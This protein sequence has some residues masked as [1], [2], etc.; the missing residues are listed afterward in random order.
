MAGMQIRLLNAGVGNTGQLQIWAYV[1]IGLVCVAL[2][3]CFIIPC[4]L[5]RCRREEQHEEDAD[6]REAHRRRD[7]AASESRISH[8]DSLSSPWTRLLSR[9]KTDVMREWKCQSG[10]CKKS[11]KK[12]GTG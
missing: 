7:N 10:K 9:N 6:E 8:S 1:V 2:L 11:G 4:C 12:K 3:A 5:K